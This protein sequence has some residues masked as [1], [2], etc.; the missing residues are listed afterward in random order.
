MAIGEWREV[1][2]AQIAA[3][4]SHMRV[5]HRDALLLPR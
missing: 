4:R 2:L 5:G 3:G 1:R